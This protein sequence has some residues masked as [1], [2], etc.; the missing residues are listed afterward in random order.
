MHLRFQSRVTIDDDARL[1]LEV[2]I[3]FYPTYVFSLSV[4]LCINRMS[5]LLGCMSFGVRSLMD[6]DKVSLNTEITGTKIFC[7]HSPFLI[8]ILCGCVCVFIRPS[9]HKFKSLV[10]CE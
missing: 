4:S 1:Y 8:F 6:P 7:Q 3:D 2:L 10:Q 5:V 9:D